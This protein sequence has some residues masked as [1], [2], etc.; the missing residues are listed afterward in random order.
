MLGTHEVIFTQEGMG[1]VRLYMSINVPG[2][3]AFF[4]K[5]LLQWER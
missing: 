1:R 5:H 2:P 3:V 4:M